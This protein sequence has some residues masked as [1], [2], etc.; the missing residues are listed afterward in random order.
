MDV[1]RGEQPLGLNMV[2]SR[3]AR[4]PAHALREADRDARTFQI[5]APD[6]VFGLCDAGAGGTG[7][8]RKGLRRPRLLVQLDCASQC[9]RCRQQADDAIEQTQPPRTC[10]L[11]ARGSLVGA[12]HGS[13]IPSDITGRIRPRR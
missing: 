8:E 6:P 12:F 9:C 5:A 4:E 3:G 2:L 7:E 11:A 13:R 1:Q 10:A